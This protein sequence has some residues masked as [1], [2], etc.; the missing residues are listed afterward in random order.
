MD[1]REF[2]FEVAKMH[3]LQKEY[4]RTRSS[5]Y[6]LAC[7]RQEKLVDREI[8]RVRGVLNKRGSPGLFDR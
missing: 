8:K 6:L 1:R 5:V 3:E 4:F 2:F 7:K